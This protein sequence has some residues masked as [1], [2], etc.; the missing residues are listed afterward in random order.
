MQTAAISVENY[1][2]AC[3]LHFIINCMTILNF[4][5]SFDY[6]NRKLPDGD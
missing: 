5:G 6:K 4:F 2:N 1:H 3:P